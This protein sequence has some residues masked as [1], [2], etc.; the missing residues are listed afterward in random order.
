[1][2]PADVLKTAFAMP[3]TSPLFARGLY[4]YT[5]REYLVVTYRTSRAARRP[6]RALHA[7]KR[8]AGSLVP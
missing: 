2:E 3:L 4:R 6:C 7:D 1:M 5:N 8:S